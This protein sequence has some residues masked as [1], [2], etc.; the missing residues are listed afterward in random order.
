MVDLVA[1]VLI[2][3]AALFAAV[4]LV[5]GLSFPL[6]DTDD[7]LK[8]IIV[9]FV[10]GLINSYLKP[11]VKL[12]SLPVSLMTMGLVGFVINAAMLMLL[13]LLSDALGLGF[14][15]AGWP[16]GGLGLD[17]IVAA[18]LGALVVSVVSTILSLLLGQKRILGIRV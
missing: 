7:W 12:L 5:P 1:R 2:N 3:A 8:L 13:A 4:K 15:I 9:A 10:F 17:V 18:L 6:S 11:I 14:S 16:E